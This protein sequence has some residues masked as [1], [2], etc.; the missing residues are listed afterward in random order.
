MNGT[1]TA[2]ITGGSAGLGRVSA[3]ALAERGWEV[4]V[5]GRR[6]EPLDRVAAQ[7]LAPAG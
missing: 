3:V 6:V 5:T 4:I 1:R 7:G 2:L